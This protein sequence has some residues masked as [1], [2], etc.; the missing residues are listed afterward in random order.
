[1]TLHDYIYGTLH[2]EIIHVEL[3][4][5]VHNHTKLLS[6]NYDQLN[7]KPGTVG[8]KMVHWFAHKKVFTCN[9]DWDR[10]R[11]HVVILNVK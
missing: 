4:Q 5:S 8:Y 6:F 3:I 10:N 11:Q 9:F 7:D 2:D 1:M